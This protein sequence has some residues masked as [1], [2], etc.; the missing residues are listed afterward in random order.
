MLCG[1]FKHQRAGASVIGE[2]ALVNIY[3][4]AE[5][6]KV[7]GLVRNCVDVLDGRPDLQTKLDAFEGSE[8]EHSGE[9]ETGQVLGEVSMRGC[10]HES[11]FLLDG[12]NN[13]FV[14]VHA[15]QVALRPLGRQILHRT[16]CLFLLH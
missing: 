14:F 5:V 10:K 6:E 16:L 4:L 1:Y 12:V 8:N 15:F 11:G 2:R 3:L 13:V 9:E 7:F